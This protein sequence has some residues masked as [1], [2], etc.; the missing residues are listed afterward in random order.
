MKNMKENFAKKVE[1]MAMNVAKESV[2]KS[3]PLCVYEVPVSK[4][5]KE[6]FNK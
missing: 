3:V 6:Y 2:G 5:V 1:K 4:E